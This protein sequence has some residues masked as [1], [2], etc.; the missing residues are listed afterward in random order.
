MPEN[1]RIDIIACIGAITAIVLGLYL[2]SIYS[3]LLFHTLIEIITIAIG[4]TL[5][6]LTWNARPV[7]ANDC[8]KILGIGYAFIAMI[9]MLHTLSYKG[10]NIFPAFGANL[11][12]QLWIAA[13][14]LQAA[15]LCLAPL[16]VRRKINEYF[17]MAGYFLVVSTVVAMIYS[18]NF[19]DCYIEG[20]GLTTFKIASEYVITVILLSSLPLFHNMRTGFSRGV[21]ALIV[22]SI[23]CTTL[24]ELAFT[25]YLSVYG[26]ANMFGHLL[27]LAAFYQIYRALLVTGLKRPFE[28]TFRELKQTEEALQKAHDHLEEQVRERTAELENEKLLL[29]SL[30]QTIPD[31][32]WLKNTQGVFLIANSSFARL[33]NVSEYEL[34]GKSDFDYLEPAQAEFFQ[35]KDR[36]AIAAGHTQTYEEWVTFVGDNHRE[37]WETSKTPLHNAAERVIGVLGVARNITGRKQLEESLAE[38]EREFRSLAENSPDNIARYDLQC[39]LKYFN[40]SLKKSVHLDFDHKL[41]KTPREA[42]EYDRKETGIY[43]DMLRKVMESG[44]PGE[45]EISMPHLSGEPHTHHIRFVAERDQPGN[46][47][48]A[49]TI[50]RDITERKR[51]EESILKLNEELEERVL[52]RTAELEAKNAELARLNKIFV[53][54]ELRMIEL[55]ERIRNLEAKTTE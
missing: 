16:F 48:G 11:P 12:T 24:S 38:R 20:Q 41:G 40:P 52:Q 15:T 10:M 28:L 54:R 13:R 37:L 50:G 30:V 26:F 44:E 4:F 21:Y 25:A 55:K 5:F 29:K 22:S 14:F 42:D 46:I 34:I 47:V 1:S 18:G 2:T 7:L 43:E 19:P 23:I 32:V 49:L 3:Y 53:G 39:R 27:K 17:L 45:I 33:F 31:P 9:D 6:I 8:L 35:H 51:M 36:D